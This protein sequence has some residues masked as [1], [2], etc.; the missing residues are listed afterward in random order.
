MLVKNKRT[1]LDAAHFFTIH[2]FLLDYAEQ[3]AGR[4]IDIRKQGKRQGEFSLEILVRLERVARNADDL[5]L[6]FCKVTIQIAELLRLGGAARRIV[7]G[8]KINHQM[9]AARAG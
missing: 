1:A 2:V 5:A 3:V 4:F 6:G 7:L 8:V 9:L